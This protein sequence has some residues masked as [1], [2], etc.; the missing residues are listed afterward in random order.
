LDSV[1]LSEYLEQSPRYY[2]VE[3]VTEYKN[4]LKNSIPFYHCEVSGCFD[5]QGTAK[6]MFK[7]IHSYSHKKAWLRNEFAEEMNTKENIDL[8]LKTVKYFQGKSFKTVVH[9]ESWRDCKK[10]RL[11]VDF[12]KTNH[13]SEEEG[14]ILLN[15]E[16]SG[17]NINVTEPLADNTNKAKSLG[18]ANKAKS[19]D[20]ALSSAAVEEAKTFDNANKAKSRDN[21]LSSAAVKEVEEDDYSQENKD[22]GSSQE[23]SHWT[24]PDSS[25]DSLWTLPDSTPELALHTNANLTSDNLLD[26]SADTACGTACI[27]IE[28]AYTAFD[29]A[30]TT[31]GTADTTFGTADTAFQTVDSAQAQVVEQSSSAGFEVET[32]AHLEPVPGAGGDA[33]SEAQDAIRRDNLESNCGEGVDGTVQQ[34]AGGGDT[35]QQRRILSLKQYK[36][37]IS[38]DRVPDQSSPIPSNTTEGEPADI[39]EKDVSSSKDQPSKESAAGSSNPP[40]KIEPPDNPVKIEPVKLEKGPIDLLRTNDGVEFVGNERSKGKPESIDPEFVYKDVVKKFVNDILLRY[41]AKAKKPPAPENIKIW[42]V[43]DFERI[44]KQLCV[45]LREDIKES[46]NAEQDRDMGLGDQLLIPTLEYD[47]LTKY[48]IEAEIERFFEKNNI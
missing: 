28:T 36:T 2:G 20:N 9:A 41:Y 27:A 39:V 48:P 35:V 34:E 46:W 38:R 12:L 15:S 43:A 33:S 24:L 22:P 23:D 47:D 40:L 11:R 6:Q 21:A 4:G 32:S 18:N 8:R 44:L 30:D 19:L 16:T 31:F 42:N 13:L 29:T 5:E 45:R 17:T 7:H 14:A 37:Q 25:K 3:K 10:A 1:H 26:S